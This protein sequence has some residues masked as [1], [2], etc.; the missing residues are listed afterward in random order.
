MARKIAGYAPTPPRPKTAI[1]LAEELRHVLREQFCLDPIPDYSIFVEGW[2]DRN[3]IERAAELSLQHEGEDLL[4]VP[5]SPLPTDRLAVL[6]P[7]KPGNPGRGGVPQLVRLASELQFYVFHLGMHAV[8]FVFDHDDAGIRAQ[9]DIRQYGYEPDLSSLTL[10]PRHHP[11]SCAQKQVVVE[12]LLS[13]DLQR[14]FFDSCHDKSCKVTYEG[15]A[16]RRFE[17]GDRT[18]G[19]LQEF[20]C[21]EGSWDDFQEIA[22]ILRRAR[23]VFGL[24]SSP[25]HRDAAYLA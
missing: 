5:G 12:D 14:R 19:R 9:Q 25:V 24:P 23:M 3:Y 10:N 15:G 22:R 21:R 4:A 6:T 1:E 20:A 17:W 13:I 7:G 16:L 11:G 8:C 2:T 18:K